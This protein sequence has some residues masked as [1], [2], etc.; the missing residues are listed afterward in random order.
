MKAICHAPYSLIPCFLRASCVAMR[1]GKSSRLSMAGWLRLSVPAV[2]AMRSDRCGI[3]AR[4]L[5]PHRVFISVPPIFALFNCKRHIRAAYGTSYEKAV[6]H[7]TRR[8]PPTPRYAGLAPLGYAPDTASLA[9]RAY[10]RLAEF[11]RRS[12]FT[13]YDQTLPPAVISIHVRVNASGILYGCGL[14]QPQLLQ[15]DAHSLAGNV[16]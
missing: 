14:C 6:R 5:N 7:L 8:R 15:T 12:T 1:N 3:I 9:F 4:K 10:H 11:I 2:G 16:K 13:Y